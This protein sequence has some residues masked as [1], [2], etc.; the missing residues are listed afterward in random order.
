MNVAN[1]YRGIKGT[2]Y[3]KYIQSD[4]S[5]A[6]YVPSTVHSYFGK[7]LKTSISCVNQI[8]KYSTEYLHTAIH[9]AI[10]YCYGSLMVSQSLAPLPLP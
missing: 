7:T 10:W 4:S 2:T 8:R 5:K 9:T 1:I 3:S 6:S